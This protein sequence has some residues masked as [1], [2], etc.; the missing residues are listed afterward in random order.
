M[1]KRLNLHK[2]K[3]CHPLEQKIK[4]GVKARRKNNKNM[5]LSILQIYLKDLI[6]NQ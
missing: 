3:I 2:E 4:A 1:N 5:I 6:D